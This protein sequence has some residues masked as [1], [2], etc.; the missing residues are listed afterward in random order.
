MQVSQIAQVGEKTSGMVSPAPAKTAAIESRAEVEKALE[1]ARHR[2]PR[3]ALADESAT[4]AAIASSPKAPIRRSGC[5]CSP[6]GP[7]GRPTA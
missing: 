4:K 6:P 5:D 3:L 2:T 7:R 1:A